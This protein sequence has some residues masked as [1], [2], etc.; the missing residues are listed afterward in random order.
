MIKRVIQAS[1]F[2]L[3]SYFLKLEGIE[4]FI[5]S[6]VIIIMCLLEVQND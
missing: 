2:G 5:A 4:I 6:L 1:L 3:L